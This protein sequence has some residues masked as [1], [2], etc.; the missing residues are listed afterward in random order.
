[1]PERCA[2]P[3]PVAAPGT[4]SP[5]VGGRAR[6]TFPARGGGDR[7]GP[8]LLV[9]GSRRRAPSTGRSASG[10]SCRRL[11]PAFCRSSRRPRRLGWLLNRRRVLPGTTAIWGLSPGAATAM[12]VLAEAHGGDPRLV[13]FMQYLRVICVASLASLIA[14]FWIGSTGSIRS[15]QVDFPALRL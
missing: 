6:R 12:M 13:A 8:R 11:A 7:V 4:G 1:S 15:D 14:R 9:A 10:S 2:W 3:A 5:G